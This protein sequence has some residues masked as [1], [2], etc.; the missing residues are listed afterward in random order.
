M[1]NNWL[2]LIQFMLLYLIT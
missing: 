1:L 2:I